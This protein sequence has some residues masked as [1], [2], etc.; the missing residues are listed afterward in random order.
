VLDD[1]RARVNRR[2][3]VSVRIATEAIKDGFDLELSLGERMI[4][5]RYVFD[6]IQDNMGDGPNNIYSPWLEGAVRFM[7]HFY[8]MRDVK[9]VTGKCVSAR[10][11][12]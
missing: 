11:K 12:I 8:E 6:S 4:L 1:L 3:G 10:C 2:K 9:E 5:R 7:Y